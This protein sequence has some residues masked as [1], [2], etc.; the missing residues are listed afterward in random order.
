MNGASKPELYKNDWIETRN[1]NTDCTRSQIRE[2][3]K[4]YINL[5]F[6]TPIF[7]DDTVTLA[8]V[9][10]KLKCRKI[11]NNRPR[12]L[13]SDY[14]FGDTPILRFRDSLLSAAAVLYIIDQPG[15]AIGARILEIL[16]YSATASNSSPSLHHLDGAWLS[17]ERVL[18]AEK[19]LWADCRLVIEPLK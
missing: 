4:K 13:K 5:I 14:Y 7:M 19:P 3:K 12:F 18:R 1:S 8:K 16:G 17:T 15:A 10:V 11:L 2:R 9:L 6:G